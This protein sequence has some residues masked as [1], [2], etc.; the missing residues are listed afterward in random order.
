MLPHIDNRITVVHRR[1]LTLLAGAAKGMSEGLILALG[2]KS[3]LIADLIDAELVTASKEY[4]GRGSSP[5]EVARLKI[6]EAGRQAI[7]DR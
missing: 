2:F 7:A 6:T 1:A 5:V 3:E 4:M